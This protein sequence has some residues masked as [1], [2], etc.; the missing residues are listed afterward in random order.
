MND[1]RRTRRSLA[2]AAVA[3]FLGSGCIWIETFEYD[4]D[5]QDTY[6]GPVD[7]STNVDEVDARGAQADVAV[8]AET[9]VDADTDIDNETNVDTDIDNETNVDAD[10]GGGGDDAAPPAA[11]AVAVDGLSFAAAYEGPRNERLTFRPTIGVADVVAVEWRVDDVLF[12]PATPFDDPA[13]FLWDDADAEGGWVLARR[14]ADFDAALV[15]DA[16]T[17]YCDGDVCAPRAIEA[18]CEALVTLR[19]VRA[20][21]TTIAASIAHASPRPAC[22]F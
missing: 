21:G 2:L 20:D 8:D 17:T 1:A 6:E 19:V 14:A 15:W 10:L 12:G 9:N 4:H 13:G 7:Q 18:A 16:S 3:A 22:W 11:T 5:Q